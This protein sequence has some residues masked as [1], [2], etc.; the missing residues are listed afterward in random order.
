MLY[1]K[2]CR[3]L[4]ERDCAAVRANGIAADIS[5]AHGKIHGSTGVFFIDYKM[6]AIIKLQYC[7]GAKIKG[8]TIF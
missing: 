5:A 7:C 8:L 3:G 4:R 2:P 6:G 1:R